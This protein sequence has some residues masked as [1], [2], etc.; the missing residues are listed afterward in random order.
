MLDHLIAQ[1]LAGIDAVRRAVAGM[2]ADELR[3]RPIPGKWSTLEVVCHL[4][5]FDLIDADRIKRT[6]AEDN[7]VIFDVDERR[8][9]ARL[10]YDQRVLE[11]ELAVIE[12]T[13][14]QVARILAS[15]PSTILSRVCDYRIGERSETQ[16]LEWHLVKAANHIAHH[17]PF[18]LQ[19]RRTLGLTIPPS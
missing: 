17:V 5:D 16:T 4:A 7:P 15:Q 12:S 9:A 11:E 10:G 14:R 2:T 13:R 8:L 6:L 18:I 19:K 3:A 1:Y